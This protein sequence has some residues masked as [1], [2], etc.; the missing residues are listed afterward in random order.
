LGSRIP[1][2][3]LLTAEG[4]FLEAAAISRA[5]NNLPEICGRVCPQDRLCEGACILQG[6]AEP[7]SIG[8]IERF[9]NEYAFAHDA[10]DV[11]HAPLNGCHV[12][13]VGSGPVGIT[14]ADEL[15]RRGYEVTVFES[16]P[17]PGGLLAN[18]IP[19]FKLEKAVVKRRL[20]ILQKRGVTFNLGMS[21][22]KDLTLKELRDHFD[23]VFLG[24]GAQHAREL[25]L[26]GA[27]LTGV[28]PSLPFIIQKNTDWET[29]L[30]PIDV[31]DRRVIVLGGGD[32]AMD[33]LRTALRAR[34]S[35][36]TCVYRRDFP[37]M[38]GS[39]REYQHALEE[40][41]EFRFLSWPVAVLGD[42]AGRVRSVRCQR[43][44]LGDADSSGR[45]APQPIP[46]TEFELPAEVVLVAYGF[47]PVPFPRGS[48]LYEVAVNDAGG[49]KVDPR[50]MTSLPG[51]FAGGDLVRGP[52]LVVYAV[53]DAR[54][55]AKE[56][57]RYLE[58]RRM[59]DLGV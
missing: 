36:V 43:V 3:L 11:D 45:Q 18:G 8:A 13:V 9:I 23:A 47:D 29:D 10:L 22:G 4:Q 40:G 38:P 15:S 7:V 28:F 59:S 49:I 42:E 39:R 51:V 48:D 20:E 6:K 57:H 56:I 27:Q 53:R 52:S 34:A 33:C 14:C 44:Q 30:P 58:A 17:T 55:A 24:F 41:V 25:D 35:H 50:F 31:Q 16:R 19:A 54:R 26:P 1:D 5:A 21:L 37:N 12:A 46:G 32:T 2:W